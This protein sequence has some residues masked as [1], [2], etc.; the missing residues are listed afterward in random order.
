[1]TRHVPGL[2]NVTY[3]A[4]WSGVFFGVRK[5]PVEEF[6]VASTLISLDGAFAVKV[7]DLVNDPVVKRF[8]ERGYPEPTASDL[9]GGKYVLEVSDHAGEPA[10]LPIADGYSELR[11]VARPNPP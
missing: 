7:P 6:G 3:V 1:M 11:L 10:R 9:A 8:R 4:E 2:L 5:S